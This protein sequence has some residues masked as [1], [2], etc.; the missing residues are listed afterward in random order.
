ME[1][2]RMNQEKGRL[3]FYNNDHYVKVWNQ[4]TITLEWI[5]EHVQLL[6]NLVPGYVIDHGSN[7][8]AF[9]EINGIPANLFDHSL[10]FM[11]RIRQFCLDN[12]KQTYPYA[13]GDWTLSN[14]I[15][16]HDKITMIDWDNVGIYTEEEVYNKMHSDLKSAFGDL[17]VF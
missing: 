12:I 6:K 2:V 1:L 15:V 17:Y 10:E 3:V 9:K 7:W 5:N 16:D 11:Q 14:M 8:I 13:H 4:D